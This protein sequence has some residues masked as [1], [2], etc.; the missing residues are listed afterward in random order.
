MVTMAVKTSSTFSTILYSTQQHVAALMT[1]QEL[2]CDYLYHYWSDRGISLRFKKVF[3]TL[4]HLPVTC[5]DYYSF[6]SCI[7][8]S[9]LFNVATVT[10]RSSF[11]ARTSLPVLTTPSHVKNVMACE[12]FQL[13]NTDHRWKWQTGTQ[14]SPLSQAFVA[15]DCIF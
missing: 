2:F 4:F 8:A 5:I 7:T 14:N 11:E 15:A 12:W 13:K 10:N 1:L 9:V 6:Y 3:Y